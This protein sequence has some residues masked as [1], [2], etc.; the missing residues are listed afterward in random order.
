M[1]I[2][3][4][5]SN[6]VRQ[7]KGTGFTN[8]QKYLQANKDNR[9][10]QTISQ[11]IGQAAQ[12]ARSGL[13]QA[14]SQ[15]A[16]QLES[17]D[18]L[19]SEASK[20]ART[21]I[22]TGL[23]QSATPSVSQQDIDQFT[24]FREGSYT[25]PQ[26]LSNIDTLINRAGQAEQLGRAV[27]REEGRGQLL[28]QFV[29]GPQ[30]TSGQR[31]FDTSLLG[32]GSGLSAARQQ[33]VGLV[34][35]TAREGR[36]AFET[37]A[38]KA[39]QAKDFGTETAKLLSDP[40]TQ[41]RTDAD[42]ALKTRLGDIDNAKQRFQYALSTGDFRAL[43]ESERALFKGIPIGQSLYGIQIADY[44]NP[45]DEKAFNV[46]SITDPTIQ[47]KYAA[48]SRLAG[49]A[50]S[51]KYFDVLGP[52]TP[53]PTQNMQ[54]DYNKFRNALTDAESLYKQRSNDLL[55]Q[56]QATE[57]ERASLGYDPRTKEIILKGNPNP[58]EE[59]KR[60]RWYALRDQAALEKAAYDKFIS[61]Q[62]V[63]FN[64]SILGERKGQR[65]LDPK[66]TPP[67]IP[68]SPII[69]APIISTPIIPSIPSRPS[70]LDYI[71]R[72]RPRLPRLPRA[73]GLPIAIAKPPRKGER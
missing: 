30:Y 41:I 69:P 50:D 47:A 33:T 62:G 71:I 23:S 68:V 21:N 22:L 25:G 56:Y 55:K 59:A 4:P 38:G 26:G 2:I 3:S 49:T 57:K 60:A 40:M 34:G 18:I 12:Q 51:D 48:L 29:G 53:A 28:Q 9:L 58:V 66:Y 27:G 13:Q 43:N 32:G 65:P 42:T 1:P 8:L 37:A 5:I 73:T 44:L 24:K 67:P 64:P 61:D 19:G 70:D 6:Q 10:G 54:F 16:S 36:Q 15:F 11:G 20:T 52:K 45:A 46:A 39:Q 7:Q 72:P 35:T 31:T 63:R 14:Q 17:P